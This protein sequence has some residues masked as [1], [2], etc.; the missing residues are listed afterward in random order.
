MN[1]TLAIRV[2]DYVLGHF[3]FDHALY[4]GVCRY[5]ARWVQKERGTNWA[6]LRGEDVQQEAWV[7]IEAWRGGPRSALPERPRYMLHQATLDGLR[8][9]SRQFTPPGQRTRGGGNSPLRV[10]P[11]SIGGFVTV[12]TEHGPDL[13]SAPDP[14]SSVAFERVEDQV[15]LAQILGAHASDDVIRALVDIALNDNTIQHAAAAVGLSRDALNRRLKV[16][17]TV[18]AAAA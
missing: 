11:H 12:F 6:D 3:P 14:L 16:L 15:A 1:R 7:K 2:E 17:R 18:L 10:D 5:A 9:V 13:V 8:S 4:E